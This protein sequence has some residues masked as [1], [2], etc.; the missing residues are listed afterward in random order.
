MLILRVDSFILQRIKD[1]GPYLLGQVSDLVFTRFGT[2]THGRTVSFRSPSWPS[3]TSGPHR[4]GHN[5][6][7]GSGQSGLS[8]FPGVSCYIIAY[9]TR[10]SRWHSSSGADCNT[11]GTA[12]TRGGRTTSSRIFARVDLKADSTQLQGRKETSTDS[13]PTSL[14][15]LECSWPPL[16]SF[17]VAVAMR[18]FSL[19]AAAATAD[20]LPLLSLETGGFFTM[21]SA[22]SSTAQMLERVSFRLPMKRFTI[23]D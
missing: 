23:L 19:L 10:G 3:S 17:L 18:L 21:R 7:V 14:G 20:L 5:V 8:A 22:L 13:I 4:F 6:D 1:G 9:A 12:W 16:A 11:A 2:T 15:P